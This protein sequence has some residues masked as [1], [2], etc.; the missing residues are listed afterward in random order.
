M[1]QSLVS[2][3]YQHT[4]LAGTEVKC[5]AVQLTQT[6]RNK[7]WGKFNQGIITHWKDEVTQ[8]ELC[9]LFDFMYCIINKDAERT[10]MLI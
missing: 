4:R 1:T 2:D 8:G 3:A 6:G 9:G 10:T 7:E 5:T